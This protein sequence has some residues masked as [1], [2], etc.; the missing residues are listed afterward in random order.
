MAKPMSEKQRK[1]IQGCEIILG[2]K[3]T[4][5]DTAQ[6][7]FLFLR[8]HYDE[9][10]TIYTKFLEAYAKAKGRITVQNVNDPIKSWVVKEMVKHRYT[11]ADYDD[12][13]FDYDDDDERPM[14]YPNEVP[15][16]DQLKNDVRVLSV[17]L[18]L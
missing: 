16:L 6:G 5:E 12:P 17:L 13:Y 7:A 3:Y 9:A 1:A 8:E 2:V 18:G 11:G 15:D 4:G 10:K 14:P